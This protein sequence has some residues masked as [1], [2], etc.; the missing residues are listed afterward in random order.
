MFEVK[1]AIPAKKRRN[2]IAVIVQNRGFVTHAIDKKNDVNVH[3]KN[4]VPAARK[5]TRINLVQSAR[6]F[7]QNMYHTVHIGILKHI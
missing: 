6:G 4:I 5:K 2:P 7:L 3:R 1:N